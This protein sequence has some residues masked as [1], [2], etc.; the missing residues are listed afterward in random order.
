MQTQKFFR[1]IFHLDRFHAYIANGSKGS[2][3]SNW[4]EYA[5]EQFLKMGFLGFDFWAAPYENLFWCIPGKKDTMRANNPR[6]YTARD[7]GYPMLIIHPASVELQEKVQICTCGKMQ[8]EHSAESPCK[9][10]IPLILTVTDDTS[11]EEIVKIVLGEK[12]N[13][14]RVIVFNEAFYDDIRVAYKILSKYLKEYPML[15]KRGI[16]PYQ[17]GCFMIFREVAD[18]VTGGVKVIGGPYALETRRMMQTLIRKCRHLHTQ[19]LLD[20]QRNDDIAASVAENRDY[21]ILKKSTDDLIPEK[22][23][24]VLK[25]VMED[26]DNAEYELDFAKRDAFPAIASI[27][28]W[29]YYVVMPDNTIEYRTFPQP[30]FM[31][32]KE[33]DDWFSIAGIIPHYDKR[34]VSKSVEEQTQAM[35][36]KAEKDNRRI[37]ILQ[38]AYSIHVKEGKSYPRIAKEDCPEWAEFGKV[39]SL[40]KAVSR[41]IKDGE[42]T[43]I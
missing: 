30:G 33:H 4:L 29:E 17:Q 26:R 41:G 2:G 6:D 34:Q 38:R 10:F 9:R 39:G 21:L 24:W 36:N 1:P 15:I 5:A 27:K 43:P 25:K 22:Y 37:A 19:L 12:R 8:S 35:R 31:H 13:L 28:P 18:L 20:S 23:Q 32:K 14:K 40:Q 3:K 42:V 7:Y 11:L 16:I